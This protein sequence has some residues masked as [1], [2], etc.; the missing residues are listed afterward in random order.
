MITWNPQLHCDKLFIRPVLPKCLIL[1]RLGCTFFSWTRCRQRRLI[2]ITSRYRRGCVWRRAEAAARR[3]AVAQSGL[4]QWSEKWKRS[5]RCAHTSP[6]I[7]PDNYTL[8]FLHFTPA[9]PYPC[10]RVSQSVTRRTP[11]WQWH[12]RSE[13]LYVQN[14]KNNTLLHVFVCF[15]NV[16]KFILVEFNLS[17][18]A[19]DESQLCYDGGI[20]IG[21]AVHLEA[22]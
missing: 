5:C 22:S 8:L 2:S 15:F 13:L 10:L 20:K 1:L 17:L 11:A 12:I 4:N 19:L 18:L 16:K 6:H 14:E 7:I 3:S 9:S 21:E